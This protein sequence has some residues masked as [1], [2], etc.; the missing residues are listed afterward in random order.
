MTSSCRQC[1]AGFEISESD[2]AFYDRVSPEFKGKKYPVPPPTFCPDCRQQRRLTFRNERKLYNAPCALCKKDIVSL[3]SPEKSFT[4]YCQPCWWGDAWDPLAHGRDFDFKRPF[5]EQFRELQ[6]EVPRLALFNLNSVN[7]EYTNHSAD[8]KNCYMGVAFGQCEDSMYGH[9]VL[10]SKDCVDG[11][12]LEHCEQCYEC[13]YCQNCYSTFFSQYCQNV[14]DSLLCYECK[15]CEYCIG[16]IQQQHKKYHILNKPVSKEEFERTKQEML[17]SRVKFQTMADQYQKLKLQAPQRSSYQLNCQDCTGNDLYNCKNASFSFNCRELEDC[18]YMYDLGNNKDSMDC[19]EH[20]WLVQSELIYESHAGMAGHTFLFCN[21]CAY[22]NNLIYCDL[23]FN[24]S[25][26]NFGSIGLKKKEY[27]I[28]N[29]QYTKEEYEE[30]V[31]KIIEHMTQ[32]KEWGEYF[33][34][35]LSVFGYNETA[36]QEYYPLTKENALQKGFNWS[37]YVALKPEVKKTLPASKLPEDIKDIPDD[38]L[39]W[40]IECEVSGKP[41]RIIK[42]ELQFYRDRNLPI[43]RRHPDE[44]HKDRM[45]LRNPRKLWARTCMNCQKEIQTTYAPDR[46]EIVYCED[47]YLKEIY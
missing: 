41:F 26:H 40:A 37:D 17:T 13:S 11:L 44:R 35:A 34:S 19:Y 42:Q 43:P 14:R 4:I 46:P 18:K 39:N 23:C 24:N 21:I 2:L 5:F 20:G 7:S 27:C 9:W 6:K 28:L 29:K 31:P 16:C 47:C 10:H 38:I 30:M 32:T 15:D 33:P 1:S 45:A 22:S 36:A 8:N 25:A 12:Y 3:Y